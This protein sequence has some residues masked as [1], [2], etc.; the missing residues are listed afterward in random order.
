MDFFSVATGKKLN[1]Y[2]LNTIKGSVVFEQLILSRL[3]VRKKWR[4]IMN[5]GL[6]CEANE[7]KFE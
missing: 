2:R 6:N 4:K 5:A 3:K 7:T 1:E